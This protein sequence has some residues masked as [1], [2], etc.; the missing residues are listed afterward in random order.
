LKISGTLVVTHIISILLLFAYTDASMASVSE[1]VSPSFDCGKV[2]AGSIEEMICKDEGLAA[3]DQK[4][5]RVYSEASRK[6]A[7]EHPPV[8]K[9]EQRG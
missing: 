1:A 5:A 6:A 7:N 8:L 4:L 2:E 9:A 3:L